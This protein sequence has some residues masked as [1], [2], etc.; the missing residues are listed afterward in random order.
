MQK[1]S[2]ATTI[3][4]GTFCAAVTWCKWYGAV[5]GTLTDDM[6]SRPLQ[7]RFTLP[8]P[9]SWTHPNMATINERDHNTMKTREG[10]YISCSK[11]SKG[12]P[13]RHLNRHSRHIQT[14]KTILC[15][16]RQCVTS[17]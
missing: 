8:S 6:W 9:R 14:F 5:Q 12:L 3:H 17:T 1:K 4:T 16:N 11:L 13:D 10:L 2:G 15:C 7:G